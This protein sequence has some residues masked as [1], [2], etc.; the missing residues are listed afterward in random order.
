[1]ILKSALSKRAEAQIH[2]EVLQELG[3]SAEAEIAPHSIELENETVRLTGSVDAQYAE[4][5]RILRKAYYED[6]GLVVPD[7]TT[8]SP[9]AKLR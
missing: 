5:R 3:T 4:L 7:A 6:L 9:A 1:M 8:G 2:A